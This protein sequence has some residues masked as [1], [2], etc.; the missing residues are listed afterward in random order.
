MV[1]WKH[2]EIDKDTVLYKYR[3]F[4]RFENV[5]DIIVNRR[6]YAASYETMNDPLEGSYGFIKDEYPEDTELV[7]KLDKAIQDQKFCSLSKRSNLELMWSHYADGHRGICFG[8]KLKNTKKGG[9]AYQ[10]RYEDFPNLS[11]ICDSKDIS[12]RAQKILRYKTDCWSYEEEV[13]LFSNEGHL[14]DVEV[15][16]IILGKRADPQLVSLINRLSEQFMPTATVITLN[17][18]DRKNDV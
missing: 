3:T 2:E 11:P 10:V 14:V 5:V 8:V 1:E 6:L 18:K 16:E 13:R 12:L 9:L 17:T 4:A 7:K 15:V